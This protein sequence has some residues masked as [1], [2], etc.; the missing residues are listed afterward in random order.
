MA[1]TPAEPVPATNP[2]ELEPQIT[3]PPAT[4]ALINGVTDALSSPLDD[5]LSKL[6]EVT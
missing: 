3:Y 1:T 2:S 5:L 4:P 6:K